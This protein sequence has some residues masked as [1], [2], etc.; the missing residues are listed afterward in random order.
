[1][2]EEPEVGAVVSDRLAV[3]AGADQAVAAHQGVEAVLLGPPE[4]LAAFEAVLQAVPR[5]M[6]GAGHHSRVPPTDWII[7]KLDTDEV[8][9]RRLP[10]HS[11]PRVGRLWTWGLP[12]WCNFAP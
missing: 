8:N 5:R 4:E 9:L 6:N 12:L 2:L 11:G 10:L 3:L 1:L 7:L